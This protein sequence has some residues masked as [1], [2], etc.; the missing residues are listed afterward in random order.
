MNGNC[1][2]IDIQP[3]EKIIRKLGIY[4]TYFHDEIE[5]DLGVQK[6][7]PKTDVRKV[8]ESTDE[9]KDLQ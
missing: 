9:V 4:E 2:S 3:D 7:N 1:S 8:S 6:N 5:V